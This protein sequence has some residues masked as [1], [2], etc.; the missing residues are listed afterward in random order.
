MLL[1]LIFYCADQPPSIGKDT[2]TMISDFIKFFTKKGMKVL[3]PFSGIGS[4]LEA[5]KRTG[6][7]GFGTEL[8]PKYY[9]L[10]LG[11]V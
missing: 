1:C 9:E 8:N 6:R 7:V 10:C 11:L 3:D 4:T 5:C 2:P